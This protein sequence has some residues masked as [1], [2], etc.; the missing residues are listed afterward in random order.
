[1]E[2]LFSLDYIF[3]APKEFGPYAITYFVIFT[4]GTIVANFVFFSG[5]YRFKDN[6]LTYTLV[7]RA[8]R[9]GAIAFTLGFIFCLSRVA[10]LPPFN[11]RLFMDVAAALLVFFIVRGIIYLV[12][13]YPKAKAEWAEVQ[14]AHAPKKEKSEAAA[15]SPARKPV[16][17][18]SLAGAGAAADGGSEATSTADDEDDASLSRQELSR[19]AQNRRERKRK[20]R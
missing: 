3:T 19:R 14:A 8:S 20:S 11:A 4:L 15:I 17:A 18:A 9:A 7:N 13:T 2:K 12:R 16:A 6:L 10:Q 1:M 5:K